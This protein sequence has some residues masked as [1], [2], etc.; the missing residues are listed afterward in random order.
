MSEPEIWGTDV[1]RFQAIERQ[2]DRTTKL[3]EDLT[4]QVGL[5]V[6]TWS[7]AMNHDAAVHELDTRR[8]ND[9]N[10]RRQAFETLVQT[11]GETTGHW[12]PERGVANLKALAGVLEVNQAQV[13]K[14][15]N[16]SPI[17]TRI[18]GD[19]FDRLEAVLE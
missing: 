19:W 8:P 4:E 12:I 9:L 15:W 5:L 13:M 17:E 16:E 2:M 10:A 14:I 7:Q 3:L 11:W 18:P 6:R 1:E